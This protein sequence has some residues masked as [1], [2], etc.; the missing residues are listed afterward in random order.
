M[1]EA[2]MYKKDPTVQVQ[3]G[4]PGVVNE[5]EGVATVSPTG[6]AVLAQ[7]L[8]K[9]ATAV[10]GLAAVLVTTLPE[11]TLA[12]KVCFAIVGLGASFGIASQG[13]RKR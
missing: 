7:T 5:Q 8:V 13:V 1:P 6:E 3:D 4:R 2:S 12:W 10:V 9:G 11:H